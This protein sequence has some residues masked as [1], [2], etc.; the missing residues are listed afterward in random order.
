MGLQIAHKLADA[1]HQVIA[2][3]RT[4]AK[5]EA[6]A[7]FGATPAKQRADVSAVFDGPVVIWLMVPAEVVDEELAEWRKVLPAGSLIIDG[8]NSDFRHSRRRAQELEAK[9][10]SFIDVGVSGGVLGYANGFSLMAGGNEATYKQIAPVLADLA[11][12]RGSY[13]RFGAAGAGHFVKMVHNAI[14][15]GLME[16][17]AEGYRLLA[18]GPYANIELAEAA[19]VWQHGSIIESKLN[20]LAGEALKESPKLSG[21]EGYVAES[22]EA[23]WA[24]ELGQQLKIPLPAI[25]A[26]FEVRLDSQKGQT[27]FATKLLAAM[28]HKF[29]G[30]A[31]NKE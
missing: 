9:G 15:Y 20:E 28:R 23:R 5:A 31:I 1:G 2:Y 8:G 18:E 13:A 7:K 21:V 24:L 22:G 30:H 26:A 27:S 17:L 3:N 19:R 4:Y 29:G 16:S 6:A 10:F 11:K 25:E 14:E 12:P